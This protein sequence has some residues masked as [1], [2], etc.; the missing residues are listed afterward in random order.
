MMNTIALATVEKTDAQKTNNN[1]KH[2]HK[3]VNKIW[4]EEKRDWLVGEYCEICGK[5]LKKI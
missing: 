2:K 4:S 3:K 1:M 5:E